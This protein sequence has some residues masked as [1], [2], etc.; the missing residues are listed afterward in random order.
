MPAPPELP[1]S[2][3]VTRLMTA[4]AGGDREAVDELL[5]VVYDQAP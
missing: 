3:D 5:P 4:A 2:D 1:E